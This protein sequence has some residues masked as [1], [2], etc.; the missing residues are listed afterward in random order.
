MLG[1]PWN[2]GSSRRARVP[3]RDQLPE[4][5]HPCSPSS[6]TPSRPTYAREIQRRRARLR[7]RRRPALARAPTSSGILNG[8]DY[9]EWDPRARPR[10]S[11]R[12]YSADDLAGKAECKADLLRTFGLPEFPDLPVVGVTS[13][14]V[15][16]KG[17][18]IVAGAWYDLAAAAAA[19]GGA[20]HGRA[21]GAGRA[22]AACS[23][24][25]PDR[26]AV[27]F[28][29]DETLAHKIMAGSDMFLM[30][31]RFEPCGL[32]QMYACATARCRSCARPA[33]S[34]T[35]SSRATGNRA[36]A[37][38]SASTTADGTGLMWALDQ[39]LAAYK[40][41]K[42]WKAL[43]EERHGP[44]L[45]VGPLGPGVTSIST[46]GHAQGLIR[47][48]YWIVGMRLKETTLAM[49]RTSRP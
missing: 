46:G 11:R 49:S 38:A 5:R 29:Y 44:G 24:R 40:D 2:L 28:A 6:S 13:R 3:R 31:S 32:T 4:G 9:D 25:D 45:L 14:L 41:K 47:A 33:A 23:E 16:Q 36:R 8:V 27:R 48:V 30:P 1:L 18:D 35:R 12:R 37:P 42:A 10:T 39:A 21:R 7:L 15:W 17:F 26:F 19:H 20:G 22:C 34:W 43:H